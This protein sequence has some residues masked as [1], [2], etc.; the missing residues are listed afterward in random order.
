MMKK[1]LSLALYA[2]VFA[3]VIACGND[4]EEQPQPAPVGKTP[5]L[6]QATLA[7]YGRATDTAFEEGDAIGLYIFTSETYLDNG[8]YTFKQGALQSNGARYWYED[9]SLESTLTA[10]YPYASTWKYSAE[11]VLFSVQTDQTSRTQYAAS[12]L[13][14]ATT[15]AAPTSEAV[16]L[17]FRHALSKM[18][19]KINNQTKEAIKG[20]SISNVLGRVKLDQKSLA[21]SATGDPAAIQAAPVTIDG[22]E[23][24]QL[25]VAPQQSADPVL[26]VTTA[27][28]KQYTCRLEERADLAAGKQYTAN[29]TLS[30]KEGL[31]MTLSYSI[32]DWKEGSNIDFVVDEEG[33]EVPEPTPTPGEVTDGYSY[34]FDMEAL[35]EIHITVSEEEW[36]TLLKLYDQ[37]ANTD[38]YI[39]CDASFTKNEQMHSFADAGLRLR[40]NTSRR[41]P[42]GD[43]GQMH[44]TENPRYRHVHFMLNLRK[45]QK[46]DEHQLGGVRKIHL[47]WHKDDPCYARELFC[48][49]LF[50]RYGIWTAL[51]TSYCR[52]WLKV[53]DSKEAYYGVYA[54]LE[55]PDERYL[56]KRIDGFGNDKGFLWKCGW[57]NSGFGAGL[58]NTN[59]DRFWH[60]D[61]CGTENRAY[62]LKTEIESFDAAKAQIKDFIQKLN[63]KTG[64]SFKSWISSVTDVEFL[65]KTYAVNV[66][67]G[68]WDDYWCNQN[69][70]YIYFNSTDKENYQ[71]FFIPYDYDNTLGTSNMIDA[72]RQNP[73]NWDN[74]DSGRQLIE[75]LLQFSDYKKIYLDALKEICTREDL[76]QPA[77]ATARI[78]S[79][80]SLIGDYVSNDTGEDMEIKDRP[81]GWSN[82]GEYR[83]LK[84]GS[85]NFF[86][87]KAASIPQN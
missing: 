40:G 27:S 55:A 10:Y 20:V 13:M 56:K 3:L 1:L 54:M 64:D 15:K 11:G 33:G 21:I 50:R 45:F 69:N 19:V 63:G 16:T 77:A 52:L 46:D 44:D 66:A 2:A 74:S 61:N 85:D 12:D 17:P 67:V 71:F 65:L 62:C 38:E 18:I 84:S 14:V 76:M 58:D 36:N 79:W 51:N 53:G 81:A 41:R 68:M 72:G 80:H 87:V 78:K 5:I 4:P 75:K 48:Y 39:H 86:E 28:G 82:H 29:A 73:L 25:I 31:K 47:K 8:L 57:S 49:D 43:G 7:D 35:P 42:E 60:D 9:K 6:L 30:A 32:E 59:D 23:G 37:D 34:I 24:W 22:A 70:Y 83:L 26:T